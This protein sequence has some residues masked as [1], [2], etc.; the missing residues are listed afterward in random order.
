MTTTGYT[1]LFDFIS[2]ITL[3]G[4]RASEENRDVSPE[5]LKQAS[6]RLGDK[7]AALEEKLQAEPAIQPEPPQTPQA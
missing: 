4:L 1:A 2:A 5:E 7:I 6:D 3:I